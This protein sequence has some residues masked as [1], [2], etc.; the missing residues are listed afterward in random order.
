MGGAYEGM[1]DTSAESAEVL[2]ERAKRDEERENEARAKRELD[3]AVVGTGGLVRVSTT[4]VTSGK[5]GEM[6]LLYST[7]VR[8]RRHVWYFFL[9]FW[10][11]FS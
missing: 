10:G 6:Q 2:Q 7:Q 4:V 9:T 1:L 11:T 5:L 8:Y 3:D